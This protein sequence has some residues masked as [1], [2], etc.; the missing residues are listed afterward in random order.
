MKRGVADVEVDAQHGRGRLGCLADFITD[1][2]SQPA[3]N[4]TIH[5]CGPA[6]LRV[7]ENCPGTVLD[8]TYE[9]LHSFSYS[10]VPSQWRRLYEEASLYRA[11]ELVV[12]AT[13]D[14]DVW[15]DAVVRIL[16]TGI[17][18]AG[19]PGRG[20]VFRRIFGQLEQLV[21]P[22]LGHDIP[23]TFDVVPQRAVDSG[24]AVPRAVHVL[25]LEGFQKWLGKGAGPL[26]VP[27]AMG[28]WPAS[29]LWHDP[30]YLLR[31]TLGGRRLVPVEIG[32]SYTSEGWSQR[33]M[34]IREY[35]RA[36]LLP[37]EPAEV[38]YLAQ[39]DLFAQI[40]AL[41]NDIVVPDYCYAATE[42]DEDSLRT[43]GLGNAEPLDEPLLNAWLGPKGTKTPLHTDPYHN[44]LCQV[45]G[46][47]YIR[48]Y[49]PSQTPNVYPRGLDEN[50]ISMEN[51]SHVDVS[52]FRASLSESCE[53][54]VEGGLRKLF[55]LFEKAKYVEAV[56]AP[57]ECMYIPVGWW[58]YVES[59]TTSF[60]VSFWWT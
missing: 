4:E 18:L 42:L 34:T 27:G 51:T 3:L 52:V 33:L 1:L 41:R 32:E 14:G 23:A 29:Q 30:N 37:S 8:L 35:M 24:S 11:S 40:P 12:E 48:L 21:T 2:L 9:K 10:K 5:L 7:I 17:I 46:Y 36:F 50:G 45:V 31:R 44:I 22:D 19:A 38:G 13:L 58:H 16:D 54:D 6:P 43:S 59:L 28:H 25:D 26:I 60:S 20:P 15:L 55:P 53:L 39:Y 57:G 49:A 47:K 56:L